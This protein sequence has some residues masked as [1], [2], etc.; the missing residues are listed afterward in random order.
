M[1]FDEQSWKEQVAERLQGWWGRWKRSGAHSLYAFIS[2][3]VLWPVVEAAQRGENTALAMLG[4]VLAGVG[5]NLL[6]EQVQRWK[7]E[8]EAA[9]RLEWE[10]PNEA[11]RQALD[12]VLTKLDVVAEAERG[13]SEANRAW[14]V[15]RLRAEVQRL[16]STLTVAYNVNAE[17]IKGSAFGDHSQ[18]I[19]NFYNDKDPTAP[20]PA[21]LRRAYLHHLFEEV[22][23]LSLA[24]VDRKAASDAEARLDL[25]AIYTG[26]LTERTEEEEKRD[27]RR[28]PPRKEEKGRRLSALALL[29]AKPRLVLLGD[30]GSG[31]ST[32]VNFV[33]LCLAGEA[34]G[35]EEANL[36]RLTAPLPQD[37]EEEDEKAPPQPW[38]HGPLLPVRVVLR[39]FA[40]RGLPPVGEE[41][42]ARHLLDFITAELER[43]ALGAYAP[44]LE[45]TLR[46]EGGL[47][48]LDGLD[49]VPEAERRREQIK[50]A[51]EDWVSAFPRCRVLVT[52]RIYA[53][54]Q[55]AWQLRGF[56]A[57][58][59]A[60][61]S[62]GQIR[63]FIERWYAHI[64]ALRGLHPDEA[65]GRAA[66][67]KRA[68][69]TSE[70]LR[71]LAERPLLLTLMAS[72]HA[73][74]GGSLP[75][76]REE[77]YADA[78][79]LLLDWWEQPKIV[80]DAQGKAVVLQPSL[81]EWLR[82]DREAMRELLN[83][84]AYEA[85]AAQPELR[86]TADIPEGELLSGLMHLSRNPEVNPARLVK[87]L[88]QRA[89]LLVPRGVGVYTFPHRTFQEYLAACYLSDHD[90]PD[91][92]AELARREP[93]RWREV[94]L[95]AG[96]K[97][98]RG[99]AFARWALVEALCFRDVEREER[100]PPEDVWGALL[101]GQLLAESGVE[102]EAVAAR[103][104][105]KLELV[106]EHLAYHV[107]CA[108]GLEGRPSL[109]ATERAAAGR[110]L[111][112]LGDPRFDPDRW[113]LPKEPLLGFV[114][115]PEG[116]FLM[117]ST[118]GDRMAWDD[119]KPQ[120]R[121][122]LLLYYI[123]RYPVTQAQF[124]AFV[125]A[126]GYDDRRWWTEAGWSWLQAGGRSSPRDYGPPFN[127]DNHPVVGITWY[128]AVAYTRWLT[129]RLREEAVRRLEAG[130]ESAAARAF[131][132]G[133]KDGRLVVTLPSEAE[134]EK[135]ARGVDGRRYPWGNDP[136]PNRA[137]Y[138]ETR[139]G[140]TS[141]VGCFPGGASLWGVEETSGNVWEW[142]RTKWE[143]SYR[144]YRGDD[145][146]EGEDPRVL[147][148]GAFNNNQ[149]YVRSAYRSGNDPGNLFDGNVGFR[150]VVLPF[151]P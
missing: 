52:S 149:L 131:W 16:G 51:V 28:E 54:Q 109:P 128:E 144:D 88:S 79:D 80:K 135:A 31:K 60:P 123:A 89:G 145:D 151:S 71:A 18:V 142:C 32:F 15:E 30:P 129:E 70:R 110:V 146:L 12:A 55:Q 25:S 111:A 72:L 81:A 62:R 39:D 13:L 113:Y 57:A 120:H 10:L 134:W 112:R 115:I 38:H 7:D 47:L 130:V 37:D 61:F 94:V 45:R 36:K 5:G 105:R 96:A 133:L 147:R 92:V 35:R 69:F 85:H 83:R 3:A 102:P 8:A 132:Q 104:R 136:D 137:N 63:R 33:A 2:A 126:G 11:L 14:F 93:N 125:E 42:T 22:G 75:E 9:R 98:G 56:E 17:V 99:S 100:L 43:H 59:L 19:N 29:D 64:G 50:Q 34:L 78:V 101:A 24:G 119:E 41:T 20:D 139:L 114:P 141:A 66:R 117:G 138:D 106:R 108:D 1:A 26:L 46:E 58:K 53:Y 140:T 27:R 67:L 48:L 73:W 124:R 143:D 44:H 68:I 150:L 116:A 118:D 65:Q 122:R 97:A 121:R 148:G 6:A 84:L 91:K 86:G 4:K 95:L 103:D 23:T 127:L 90:Y 76:K 21:T 40:A 74:R 77:L 82:V 87:Y 49:E 107:L